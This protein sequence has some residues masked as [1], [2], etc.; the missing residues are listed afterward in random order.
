LHD[1]WVVG[2]S[3][4]R[5]VAV[6]GR[7]AEEVTMRLFHPAIL[8]LAVLAAPCAAHPTA[9]CATPRH[10]YGERLPGL[11][12]PAVFTITNQGDAPLVLNPQPCCGIVVSG[13]AAPIPPG[14]TRQ[15]VVRAAHLREGLY[16]KTVHVFTNDPA[17]PDLQLQLTALGK[18]PIVLFPGDELT[19]PLTPGSVVTERVSLHSND[20]PVLKITSI[21][22]SAPY[23]HCD[24]ITPLLAEGKE[25]GRD[26]AVEV[27]ATP[28]APAT[29]YEAVVVLGTNSRRQPEVRLRIFGASPDAVTAQPPRIDFEPI[30]AKQPVADAVVVLTRASGPFKLL[31]A[32]AS[33][34][35]MQVTTHMDPSSRVGEV[36]ASFRPGRQRGRFQGVITVRTSDP[37][38]PRLLI[39]YTGEAH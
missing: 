5:T 21:R 19:L 25:P 16:R 4:Q 26:R 35:R 12:P 22:C 1:Q 14:A 2:L 10:D 37:E 20:E 13:A 39:P 29:P 38:R 24:E 9:Q 33:D 17:T 6:R 7:G 8:L 27:F 11:L 30:D 15:L 23:L 36:V 32:T 28:D 34:P 18:S 3:A 31:S